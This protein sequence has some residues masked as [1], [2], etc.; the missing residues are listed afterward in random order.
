[1]P[2]GNPVVGG[3]VLR[4]AAIQSPNYVLNVTGW[5]IRQDGTAQFTGV[6]L[7]GGS[8]TGTNFIINSAGTFFY[9]GP[10]AHGNLIA[11][12]TSAGGTD[13][14]SNT[15][16][17]GIVSYQ[18]SGTAV[19]A[20]L[21]AGNL[22]F[23]TP[24]A[25]AGTGGKLPASIGLGSP[26]TDGVLSIL[27]GAASGTDTPSPIIT[28]LSPANNNNQP[29]ISLSQPLLLCPTLATPLAPSVAASQA[30]LWTDANGIPRAQQAASGDNNLY[31]LGQAR[32][33]LASDLNSNGTQNAQTIFTFNVAAGIY[34]VRGY[35]SCQGGQSAGAINLSFGGTAVVS[36]MRVNTRWSVFVTAGGA[37]TDTVGDI[38]GL[39]SNVVS[40]TMSNGN[41]CSALFDG[42]V[43]F[44]ASGTFILRTA[45]S[46]ALD[47]YTN[48]ANSYME[49]AP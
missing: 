16:D 38:L 9:S 33:V 7:V 46:V 13:G 34:R 35:M 49:I 2:W 19:V 32:K 12:I 30:Q 10:P 24:A 31:A 11:S 28:L 44:S 1:M 4:R 5:A 40:P 48:K 23:G 6:V 15:Y 25:M 26:P 37:T 42:V 27:P 8:F 43:T 14:F 17:A 3:T 36:A 22:N 18:P 45:Q 21:F 47:T 20:Q 29:V 39:N 41:S